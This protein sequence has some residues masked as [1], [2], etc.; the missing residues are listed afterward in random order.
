MI[1]DAQNLPQSQRILA[2]DNR[3]ATNNFAQNLLK[4]SKLSNPEFVLNTL[5]ASSES[6]QNYTDDVLNF[7]SE[8]SQQIVSIQPES[9]RRDG[10]L[11]K[12]MGDY[13][14]VKELFQKKNFIPDANS[15]LRLTYGYIRGYSPEDQPS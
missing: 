15:T 10:V 7:Q 9:A 3:S 12:L 4:D 1:S 5:L 14:A 6:L 13:V 8:L 2:V 11:N